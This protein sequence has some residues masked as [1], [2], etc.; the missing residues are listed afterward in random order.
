ME[1][2]YGFFAD[3]WPRTTAI[4]LHGLAGD[5]TYEVHDYGSRTT[6][7]QIKGWSR[8]RTPDSKTVD[9]CACG[10]WPQQQTEH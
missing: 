1:M 7:G 8:T 6:I 9:C 10:Q 2:Y 4:E 3:N 5:K